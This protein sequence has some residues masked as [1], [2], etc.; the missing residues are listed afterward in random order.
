MVSAD[1]S[2]ASPAPHSE[3]FGNE[4]RPTA[5]PVKQV[6]AA[7]KTPTSAADDLLTQNTR[8]SVELTPEVMAS[9]ASSPRMIGKYQV[10]HLL[11][12]GGMGAVYRALD[13]QIGRQV[14]LKLIR[15]LGHH[16]A[17][18]LRDQFLREARSLARLES[19][20]GIVS[21]L[22]HNF[23]QADDEHFF[24]MR[25]IEGGTLR[26]RITS[27]TPWNSVA[28]I[29]LIQQLAR[30]IHQAHAVGVIHRDLKPENIL[31]DPEGQPW[32]TDFGIAWSTDPE[33]LTR[34]VEAEAAAGTL[35]YMA[36]EQV[37][38]LAA[39]MSARTDVYAL[40]VMLY[41]LLTGRLPFVPPPQ[42]PDPAAY[43]EA[44]I[45]QQ[46]PFPPRAYVSG[47]PP[48][49]DAIV[50]KCLAKEPWERY[51]TA[52]DLANDLDRLL[53]NEPV[54]AES[55]TPLAHVWQQCRRRY[56]AATSCG[57]GLLTQ[58]VVGA[59]GGLIVWGA[60]SWI[61]SPRR[62]LPPRSTLSRSTP[63]ASALIA[64]VV[65]VAVSAAALLPAFQ[66]W[67][68]R[69]QD[70]QF[71]Y[72]GPRATT[73]PVVIVG[74]DAVSLD[75][76]TE[77]LVSL[78]PKLA[79]TIQYL[80]DHGAAAIGIDFMIPSADATLPEIQPGAVGDAEVFGQAIGQS[81]RVI[82]P[83][84]YE[85]T[86]A[87]GTAQRLEPVPQWLAKHAIFPEW[88]DL[89]DVNLTADRDQILR[90]QVLVTADQTA[91]VPQFAL[92]IYGRQQS[93]SDP[94]QA[95]SPQT[96]PQLQLPTR[97]VVNYVGPAGTVPVVSMRDVLQA[98]Q[99]PNDH[100]EFARQWEGKMVLIGTTDISLGDRHLTPYSRRPPFP[101]WSALSTPQ[102][103]QTLEDQW[104]AGVEVQANIVA[105]LA[106]RA[107]IFR[108]DL[109]GWM[110]LP[111]L[112]LSVGLGCA[113][114]S[115]RLGQVLGLLFVA[116]ATWW[117]L[118][119]A[120]FM[121]AAISIPI[122]P[123]WLVCCLTPI[124]VLLWRASQ[125]PV[126]GLSTAVPGRWG[127]LSKFTSVTVQ[128]THR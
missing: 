10:L 14:A 7:A 123:M 30:V 127:R 115:L 94:W 57:A 109:W 61:L 43:L 6:A 72:R 113:A 16:A 54:S 97:M 103:P 55:L 45:V 88:N 106:D 48:A 63:V 104:M 107:W 82:L 2:P 98:A 47:L 28:A 101:W 49:L 68:R 95:D 26:R 11:G 52:E 53:D 93:W 89:G 33:H 59:A 74:I 51:A 108:W 105:S 17:L 83:V 128:P 118:T 76:F 116:Q 44:C 70:A 64:L 111:F 3:G 36:P 41:E 90:E 92:A 50:L 18:R 20:P 8:A 81:G 112:V 62:A 32:I 22:D 117:L 86:T 25:L 110:G 71:W 37:Q 122:V 99:D 21:V 12:S 60:L 119:S 85:S 75:E 46:P 19:V 78:S 5:L 39:A 23:D 42:H 35:N 121:A 9:L 1:S 56:S 96:F 114:G 79:T 120:I 27:G 100:P 66:D 125:R 38:G 91:T 13:P 58:A 65:C 29:T 126:R 124:S 80:S 31:I 77:S 73:A 84:Q 102:Q 24:T 34:S 67:E 4:T 87:E 40:G 69:M 15:S